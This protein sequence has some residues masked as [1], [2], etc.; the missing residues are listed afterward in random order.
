MSGKR[1]AL[2]GDPVDQSLSPAMQNAALRAAG[3]AASYEGIR[4]GPEDLEDGMKWLCKEGFTGFN[5]TVPHK[6]AIVRHLAE[7]E[8]LASQIG[9]VNTV[10]NLGER[11]VGFN[12]DS[13][14]FTE[15]MRVCRVPVRGQSTL[16]LGAGGAARA[17]THAL[18]AL[19]AT[20]SVANRH[21]ERAEELRQSFHGQIAALG[22]TDDSIPTLVR[23]SHLVVNATS[24]GMASWSEV[25][26][27][28]SGIEFARDTVVVDL[29]YGRQTPLLTQ[30]AQYGCRTFDGLEMLVQQGA[31]SFRIWTGFEP[32][33]EVMRQACR[34]SLTDVA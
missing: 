13:A 25:S 2:I 1:F 18:L 21:P 27:L 22:L 3:I 33:V 16:V 8:P 4:I 32:D 14:G 19:N 7:I 11:L 20:V 31:G 24:M 17:V 5:V 10:A 28:S 30:A 23:Q 15:A 9:A 29:V 26:P 12:T 34:S 6:E